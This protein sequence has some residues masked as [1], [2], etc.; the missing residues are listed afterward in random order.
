MH[1]LLLAA[2]L[3]AGAVWL[4]GPVMLAVTVL[5]T[6]RA[7]ERLFPAAPSIARLGTL[8][9]AV[10]AFAIAH[11]GAYMNHTTAAA[12]ATFALY[13]ALRVSE[14]R[15]GWA[16]ATGAALGALLATRP[17]SAAVVGVVL[18]FVLAE[19]VRSKPGAVA[20]RL[21][22]VALGALP[23]VVALAAFNAHFFGSATRFGYEAAL[24]PAGGLGFG[25]D[26]WGNAFGLAQAVA[27]T[28]AELHALSLFLLETPFPVVALIGVALAI[29]PPLTRGERVVAG[30]ALLPLVANLAYWHHGLFMGPRML[31]ESAPAWCLLAAWAVVRTVQ[32]VPPTH[33]RTG[34][35]SPRVFVTGALLAAAAA[36]VLLAPTRLAGYRM[37]KPEALDAAAVA[38]ANA[39]VRDSGWP[40]AP[41]ARAAPR[42]R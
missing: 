19:D 7:A 15:P 17:L 39:L 3:R 37:G 28:V 20:M 10:S 21:A 16:A 35:Y 31:N 4:V 36:A 40:P 9:L 14:G 11:A 38:P 22:L 29:A 18:L 24:G 8:F 25:I 2:G 41:P 30:L 23:F 33:A 1:A 26:P 6:A 13:A 34:A 32:R 12:F 5:F 42:P 27:Y